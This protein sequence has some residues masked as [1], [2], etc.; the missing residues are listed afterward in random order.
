MPIF[1]IFIGYDRPLY[2]LIVFIIAG[3]T[4]ALDGYIA[5]KFNMITNL[6][7]ILDPIAD[8]TLLV[9]A[10]IF[11]YNSHLEIKFPYWLVVI[12][13][14]RDIY[15]LAGA[16]FIYFFKGSV[17]VKP[18][19]FGKATTFFQ[20]LSVIAVL[21]ANIFIYPTYILDIIFY[22]AAGF[23]LLS[24]ILYTRYGLNQL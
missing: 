16:A 14:S 23:T 20:I 17:K 10:Y 22:I 9:S 8:K 19:F 11:I 3:I 13:I 5:R 24:A 1:I 2:A 6:G 18:S 12:V 7:K 15:L 4:D 21:L